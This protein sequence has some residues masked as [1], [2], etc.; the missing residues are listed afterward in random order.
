MAENNNVIDNSALIE[1]IAKMR[2]DFNNQTQS[3]VINA[4][5]KSTFLIPA[6]IKK[7]EP[8]TK[9][10]QDKDNHLRFQTEEKPAQARFMLI[11][12]NKEQTFFPVFT[13]E[14]E[15]KK[16][17]NDQGFATVKMKFADIAGLTEQSADTIFGFVINPMGHNLPFT[18]EML[19]SIKNTL[20]E[21][22]KKRDAEQAAAQAAEQGITA[23]EGGA[24]E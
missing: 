20:I 17:P 11:K 4:A 1:A 23:T 5:L 18:K 13:D 22:K 3:A 9:L 14:E 15:F 19:A 2:E 16:M 24:E 21:A 7:P 10:I 8:E 6:I 12:N